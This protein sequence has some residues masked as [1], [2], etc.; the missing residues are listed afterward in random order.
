MLLHLDVGEHVSQNEL[1]DLQHNI[2]DKLKRDWVAIFAKVQTKERQPQHCQIDSTCAQREKFIAEEKVY[3]GR[4][5]CLI[6]ENVT[7]ILRASRRHHL[8]L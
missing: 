7:E 5:A 2:C 1:A 4:H 6:K 8:C 3:S